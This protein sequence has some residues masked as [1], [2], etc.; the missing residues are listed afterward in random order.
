MIFGT[1]P[2][3]E[4]AFTIAGTTRRSGCAFRSPR[5]ISHRAAPPES[6][7]SAPNI[8]WLSG[9]IDGTPISVK[10]PPPGATVPTSAI[11]A[12]A[13]PDAPAHIVEVRL[14]EGETLS[15]SGPPSVIV[16]A[17]ACEAVS[18]VAMANA[19]AYRYRR[20]IIT[21]ILRGERVTLAPSTN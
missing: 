10:V 17:P 5:K 2:G 6:V 14:V 21:A 19:T 11:F 4:A 15:G 1:H 12:S 18:S 3:E 16:N 7:T 9:E 8:T 20:K 13:P